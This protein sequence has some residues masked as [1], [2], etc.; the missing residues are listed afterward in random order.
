MCFL[1]KLRQQEKIAKQ[2][3]INK[4]KEKGRK[5]WEEV[6]RLYFEKEGRF[7][8]EEVVGL[9]RGNFKGL[10]CDYCLKT[11]K[12]CVFI[13]CHRCVIIYRQQEDGEGETRVCANDGYGGCPEENH[14]TKNLV[15]LEAG[16]HKSYFNHGYRVNLYNTSEDFCMPLVCSGYC[17]KIWIVENAMIDDSC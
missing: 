7:G 13:L 4:L 12:K 9:G 6:K 2:E 11:G 10:M 17:N 14:K 16:A 15:P 1:Q 8:K 3:R 5:K